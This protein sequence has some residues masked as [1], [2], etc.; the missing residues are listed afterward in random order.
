MGTFSQRSIALTRSIPQMD[1]NLRICKKLKNKL[2]LPTQLFHKKSN[3]QQFGLHKHFRPEGL[4]MFASKHVNT[5][6]VAPV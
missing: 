5:K 2:I 4:C 1:S 6:D 3:P